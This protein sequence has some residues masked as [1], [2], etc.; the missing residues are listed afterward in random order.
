MTLIIK[1]SDNSVYNQ[2]YKL[3]IKAELGDYSLPFGEED[4]KRKT[5]VKDDHLT[6][7]KSPAST[8]TKNL[9]KVII[10]R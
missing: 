2:L 7:L 3:D 9:L 4:D 6:L 8:E 5:K 10:K 1:K